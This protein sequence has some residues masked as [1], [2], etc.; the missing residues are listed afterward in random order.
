[1]SLKKLLGLDT[2]P[3]TEEEIMDKIQQAYRNN[4]PEIEFHNRNKRIKV[5]LSN[6]VPLGV[7]DAHEAWGG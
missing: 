4:Q 6:C 5:S 2:F 7:V 1:M 3:L